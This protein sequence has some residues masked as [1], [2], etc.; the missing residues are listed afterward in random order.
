MPAMKSSVKETV[1]VSE[2]SSQA[3]ILWDSS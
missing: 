1:A 2:T 3:V